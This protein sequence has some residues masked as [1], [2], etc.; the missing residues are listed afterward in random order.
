[1]AVLALAHPR[2]KDVELF[3]GTVEGYIT[4]APR[5]DRGFGYDPIF[6]LP[7][8]GKTFA[9][10]GATEKSRYSHRGRALHAFARYVRD[11]DGIL[12]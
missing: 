2:R 4:D 7:A 11:H 3:E 5:G 6:Y 1:V 10:M 12:E 8:I 9:E